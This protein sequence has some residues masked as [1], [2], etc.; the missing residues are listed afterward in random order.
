ML[1]CGCD[2]QLIHDLN[3]SE[4]NRLI[5]RLESAHI[6]AAKDKQADGKWSVLVEHDQ[7]LSA[8]R[9]L[10][11]ARLL[12]SNE[13]APEY[14]SSMISSRDEQ[15]FHFERSLS[16]E[17]ESTLIK[18]RGVLEARVHL[19][20][21]QVDPLLGRRLENNSGSGSVLL[22][23]NGEFE[24]SNEEIARLV[25]GA[26]GISDTAVSILI[27]KDAITQERIV[28]SSAPIKPFENKTFSKVAR[29]GGAL[30][31]TLMLVGSYAVVRTLR[32]RR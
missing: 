29:L 19:N 10:D 30:G 18:V 32:R 4:A 28:S 22:V 25:S 31:S 20:L 2:E 14:Q 13:A 17:I 5:T 11:Q 23:T 6:E 8:L 27:S 7:Y 26:A 1:L 21:P 9:Y 16:S 15:R 24:L 3:E 12:K